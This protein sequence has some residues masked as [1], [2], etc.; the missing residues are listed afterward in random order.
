M[1][2]E[3]K[4]SPQIAT[5]DG[6]PFTGVSGGSQTGRLTT[7]QNAA[8]T[9][10][11]IEG[12]VTPTSGATAS[13]YYQFVR[14]PRNAIIKSVEVMQLGG[15]ITTWT[16][17]VTIGVSDSTIDGTQPSLQVVPSGLTAPTNAFVANPALTTTGLTG[18]AALFSHGGTPLTTANAGA[19]TD[20]TFLNAAN[21]YNFPDSMEPLW[22]AAGYSQ[23]PGGFFDIVMV[24]SATSSFTG[25]MVVA[26]RA[27]FV[28]PPG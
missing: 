8:G 3:N 9:I 25:T 12:Y 15:T 23:D 21:E 19:W 11:Q 28:L 27:K 14:V 17:D 6:Y 4:Q 26:L 16:V 5:L 7:G 1:T 18:T 20:V 24:S 2:T 10:Q 22:Q 13:S